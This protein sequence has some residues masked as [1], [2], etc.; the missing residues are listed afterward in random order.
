[1]VSDPKWKRLFISLL[2]LIMGCIGEGIRLIE[3]MNLTSR[4]PSMFMWGYLVIG[5]FG[6]AGW[7]FFLALALRGRVKVPDETTEK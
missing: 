5:V 6:F 7:G 4:T 3:W 2:L 1:M